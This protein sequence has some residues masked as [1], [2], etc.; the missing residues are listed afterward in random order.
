[1][2]RGARQP[3]APH[4]RSTRAEVTGIR[5]STWSR[6]HRHALP[7]WAFCCDI[8]ALEIRANRG[9]VAIIEIGEIDGLPTE[10]RLRGIV[11]TKSLQLRAIEE[12]GRALSVPYLFALISR[13]LPRV[14][15][16]DVQT[17]TVRELLLTDFAALLEAL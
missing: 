7:A 4:R 13:T 12:V 3:A 5:P 14:A 2:S 6:W 1:M 8:D 10:A 16:L 15:V 17:D 11:A 9:I